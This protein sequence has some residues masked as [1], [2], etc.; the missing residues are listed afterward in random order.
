MMNRYYVDNIKINIDLLLSSKEREAII[1]KLYLKEQLVKNFKIIR[2]SLDSR[3]RNDKGIFYVYSVEFD[4]ERPLK[5]KKVEK[6]ET[7]SSFEAVTKGKD[8]NPIIVGAGPGGLFAGLYLAKAGYKPLIFER[9]EDI[10]DRVNSVNTFFSEGILNTK[11]NIA[12]G[13]GGAGTFSDGKLNSRIKSPYGKDVL[14]FLIRCGGSKEIAYKAKPHLGTDQLRKVV[15]NLKMEIES[16]GGQ[17]FFS[18]DVTDINI[19]DGEVKSIVVNEKDE[20]P[21]D[22]LILAVGN[23]AKDIFRMLHNKG[24]FL[25]NKPFAVGFRVE[26]LKEEVD[27]CCYGK[28]YEHSALKAS[29]YVLKYNDFDT[30]RGVYSFCNCPGGVVVASSSDENRVVTNG[31]SFYNRN[32]INSNSAIVINVNEEDYGSDPLAGLEFQDSLEEKAFML[33]GKN[34]YAPYSSIKDYLEVSGDTN[35]TP[36]YKPGVKEVD[37][38]LALPYELN[39]VIKKGL[40]HF[41]NILPCFNNGVITGIE[42]RTSS[43]VRIVRD[44]E[45]YESVNVKG[46]YPI[47]EGAGYAGGILSSCVDGINLS[48][49][50]TKE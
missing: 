46:L 30:K 47:G 33:G 21:T 28:Y 29:E 4:Y 10:K 25:E 13:L 45:T 43:A 14:D 27:K 34:Y 40:S 3:H 48:L 26:H 23:G 44:K 20:Y 22:T 9:G 38:N 50:L 2:K 41:S 31:M 35:T 39:Y 16:L 7:L 15:G 6:K 32:M 11:S 1:N 5:Y 8:R 36:T 12:F 19:K 17:F 37:M 18:S 24:V 49:K 42:T